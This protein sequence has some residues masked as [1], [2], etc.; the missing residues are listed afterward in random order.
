MCPDLR[1]NHDR[2]LRKL[3]YRRFS[4]SFDLFCVY[5]YTSTFR[6]TGKWTLTYPVSVT[7]ILIRG[8]QRTW[9]EEFFNFKGPGMTTQAPVKIWEQ[10]EEITALFWTHCSAKLAARAQYRSQCDKSA[11]TERN[12]LSKSCLGFFT[13]SSAL[14]TERAKQINM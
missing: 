11:A 13:V 9:E 12:S 2:P 3:G 4:L 1:I 5:D 10:T 6:K 14:C 7:N 8:F